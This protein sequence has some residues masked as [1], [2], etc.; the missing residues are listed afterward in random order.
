MIINFLFQGGSSWRS[1]KCGTYFVIALT[2]ILKQF[3]IRNNEEIK[4]I[5]W[6]VSYFTC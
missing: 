1:E 4:E 2:S 5:F 3:A 6:K